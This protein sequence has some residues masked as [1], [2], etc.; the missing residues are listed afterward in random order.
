MGFGLRIP[1]V[2]VSTRG[3]RVGPKFANVKVGRGGVRASVGPRIARV[4]VGSR[5]ITASTGLGPVHISNL[6]KY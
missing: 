4:S 6:L 5:G 1:G 2:R 3:I